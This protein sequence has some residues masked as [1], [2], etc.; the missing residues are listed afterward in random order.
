MPK[1]ELTVD[2]LSAMLAATAKGQATVLE[3][4]V[5]KRSNVSAE[6]ACLCVCTSALVCMYVRYVRAHGKR[7]GYVL[8]VRGVGM[9]AFCG[10]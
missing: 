1:V 4:W 3:G 2:T 8:G 6:S 9:L 5:N 7:A 10:L